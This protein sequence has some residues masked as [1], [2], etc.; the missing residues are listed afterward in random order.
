[1]PCV[2]R[3]PQRGYCSVIEK[4]SPRVVLETDNSRGH[5]QRVNC[6]RPCK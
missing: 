2:Y 5:R 1:M 6:I 4:E 3:E